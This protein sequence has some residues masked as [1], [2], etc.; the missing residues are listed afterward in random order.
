MAVQLFNAGEELWLDVLAGER[1]Q[2]PDTWYIGLYNDSTDKLRDDATTAGI[3][4]EPD[5]DGPKT[6]RWPDDFGTESV[7]DLYTLDITASITF[8]VTVS[9]QTVDAYYVACDFQ[10]DVLGQV[11]PHRNL[12]WSGALDSTYDLGN[13]PNDSF[14]LEGVRL[15][16]D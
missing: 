16:A 14:P 13:D 2:P 5:Y 12:V 8:D 11:S 7:D 6:V 15:S 9:E 4:T 10:S 1:S 3:T